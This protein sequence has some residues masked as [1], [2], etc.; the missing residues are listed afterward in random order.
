M[1]IIPIAYINVCIGVYTYMY[2][3]LYI[4]N[5]NL[6]NS[7]LLLSM[8]YNED[9]SISTFPYPRVRCFSIW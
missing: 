4:L 5:N 1:A 9:K 8:I 3:Y 2:V 7:I 6:F